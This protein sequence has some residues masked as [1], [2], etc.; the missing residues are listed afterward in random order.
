M[1]SL[2]DGSL[3]RLDESDMFGRIR[4]L[5]TELVRAWKASAGIELPRGAEEAEQVVVAGMG[6][7]ATAG[8]YFAALCAV[9]AEV[10]V[11]VVRGYTLPNYVSERTLVVLSSYSGDTEESLACYDDA[12]KRGAPILA[13]TTGGRLAERAAQ[14]GVPV[15]RIAY[16]AAPR[17]AL[18]HS[19]APLLRIGQRLSYLEVGDGEV[20]AAGE[21]H[22]AFVESEL[23]PEVPGVR[24]GAKQLAL[25]L[26]GRIALVLGGE[27][28]AP[29]ASRCK[30]QLAENGKALGAADVLPEA[31]HNLVVGLGTGAKAG[32][33]LSLV[34][35]EAPGG[36]DPRVQKRFEVT[37]Q[38][39][40]E[41][42]V[43]VHRLLVA[44]ETLLAEL[45]A[46]TAWGDYVSCYL[47]LL[48]GVDPTPVPQ[49]VR[50]K[51]ALAG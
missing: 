19:L 10:P 5:G 23:A 33:S 46:G 7:S 47:A 16:R 29:V 3:L 26:H 27:H 36:Y 15:Y 45:L 4:E 11:H 35:L 9:S 6:G 37:T 40:A 18:P 48:N 1:T 50:L 32:Q 21:A 44:G 25:A 28:L 12:W 43:P 42:G 51:A 30:N 14:D 34:T 13:T 38:L 41:D 8:D 24:N 49:I 20:E 39:F 31:D 2:D 17:A 22:Q